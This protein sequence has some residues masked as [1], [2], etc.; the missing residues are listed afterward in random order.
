[1][2]RKQT[3]FVPAIRVRM[4][5]RVDF[6]QS[7]ISGRTHRGKEFFHAADFAEAK[8]LGRIRASRLGLVSDVH[9]EAI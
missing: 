5:Y 4:L 6:F 7:M 2:R 9:L 3:V 1:M 8:T